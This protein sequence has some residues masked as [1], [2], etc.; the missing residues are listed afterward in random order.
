MLRFTKSYNRITTS[1][2][3]IGKHHSLRKSKHRTIAIIR[4][5]P[6]NSS[7]WDA[8]NNTHPPPFTWLALLCVVL[9]S[10]ALICMFCFASLCFAWFAL[11]CLLC[12]ALLCIA[13]LRF[14]RFASLC[15]AR[16]GGYIWLWLCAGWSRRVHASGCCCSKLMSADVVQILS[17]GNCSGPRGASGL[18]LSVIARCRGRHRMTKVTKQLVLLGPEQSPNDKICTTLALLNTEQQ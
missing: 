17:V 1:Y 11:L 16:W 10:Y 8:V 3:N 15:I 7:V 6:L 18:D 2:E 12:F 9:L 13:L 5:A 4:R 14:A